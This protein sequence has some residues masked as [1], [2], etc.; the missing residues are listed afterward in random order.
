[1]RPQHFLMDVID[2]GTGTDTFYFFIMLQ[3]HQV[4]FIG[5]SAGERT[6]AHETGMETLYE[7]CAGIRLKHRQSES[8][9]ARLAC[10]DRLL[11]MYG[12]EI[13]RLKVKDTR[14]SYI[15]RVRLRNG[16]VVHYRAYRLPRLV[17]VLSGMIEEALESPAATRTLEA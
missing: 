14:R 12:G 15:G 11:D 4:P 17:E 9:E 13:V 3:N 6:S 5:T 1:M 7:L 10:R 16:R 2:D 8:T